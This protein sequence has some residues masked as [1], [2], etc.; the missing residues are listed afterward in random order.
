MKKRTVN[1][2]FLVTSFLLFI[3][4]LVLTND[5]VNARIKVDNIVPIAA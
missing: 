5:T 2:I 4:V 1:I 3:I